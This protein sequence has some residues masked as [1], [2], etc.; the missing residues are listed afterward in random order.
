MLDEQGVARGAAALAARDADLAGIL[1]RRGV[2]PLWSRE[3]SFATLVHIILEQQVS[4]AS[5]LRAYQRL[6]DRLGS[7]CPA[8]FLTLDDASLKS[9]GF[10][11]QKT[12]YCRGVADAI[13]AGTLD[14]EH[15]A[16]QPDEVVY[17]ELTALKGIGTWTADIVL[18][19]VFGRPDVWPRGDIAL[20]RS[21]QRVK[22][23]AQLPNDIEASSMALQWRP[24]RSVAARLLWHEYLARQKEKRR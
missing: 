11:R 3:A 17:R 7:I 21:L 8:A 10:S 14:L 20:L 22:G 15:L 2:P 24:W 23:L 12:R 13:L 18:L 4:L 16:E 6:E 1:E 9:I 19:M 5:A